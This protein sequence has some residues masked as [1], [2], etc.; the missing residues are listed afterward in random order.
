MS[1]TQNRPPVLFLSH[2]APPL[3]DDKIW[4]DQL[5]SWS[6]DLPRPKN[7]LVVSAHW[8]QDPTTVSAYSHQVPLVYDFWGFPE[9]YFQVT[10]DSP[11]APE[12][13]RSVNQLAATTDNPIHHDET[14]QHELV[15][16]PQPGLRRTAHRIL[17]VR[18][19][20]HRGHGSG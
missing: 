15:Q 14:R 19:L 16:P 1:E 6:A 2:G 20:G 11:V 8:E 3:A 7:I 10:Y 9:K 4:T 18:P 17:R 5:H 13:A 12:L